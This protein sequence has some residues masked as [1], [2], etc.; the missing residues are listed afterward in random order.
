METYIITDWEKD[1]F[2]LEHPILGC[3][4]SIG[5]SYDD[6][7]FTVKCKLIMG[8]CTYKNSLKEEYKE[9]KLLR[10]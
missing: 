3:P 4:N 9:C 10:K 6:D 8:T 7:Y 1:A 5:I 2:I